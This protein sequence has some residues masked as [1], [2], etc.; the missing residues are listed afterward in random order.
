M[1]MPRRLESHLNVKH[2]PYSMIFHS[3]TNRA[4]IAAPAMHLPGKEVAKAD[5]L[6]AGHRKHLDVLAAFYRI[7]FQK[8]SAI[9][10][11][12]VQLMDEYTFFFFIAASA[13]EV[14]TLSLHDALPI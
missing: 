13:P 14:Y 9:V 7:N 3:P 2:V 8:L 4:H 11:A 10:C 12:K 6:K 1:L 5:A